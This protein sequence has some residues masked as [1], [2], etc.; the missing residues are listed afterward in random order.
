M[1]INVIN[2]SQQINIKEIWTLYKEIN[3]LKI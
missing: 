2:E 1:N 3:E